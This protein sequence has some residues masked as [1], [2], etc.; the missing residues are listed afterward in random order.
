M[1]LKHK[2]IIALGFVLLSASS[3]AEEFSYERAEKNWQVYK[4]TTDYKTYANEFVEY[5]NAHQLDTRMGCYELGSETVQL[6]LIIDYG[7][8]KRRTFVVDAVSNFN[9]PRSRCF[10]DSYKG[11]QMKKPP[12]L[13]FVLQMKFK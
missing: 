9:T 6:F 7:K 2:I 11:M 1:L 5:N 13:P 3:Q 12:Y 8:A 10:I 4:E